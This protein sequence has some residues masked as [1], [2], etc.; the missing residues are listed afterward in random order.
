M[1]HTAIAVI[2]HSRTP[3][4]DDWHVDD[5]NKIIKQKVVENFDVRHLQRLPLGTSYVDQVAHVKALLAR[6]PLRFQD[7][8]L[9]LD[10]T[11][12]GAPVG[13]LFEAGGLKPIRV[14]F[15]A[16]K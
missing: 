4:P 11:G 13:D 16:S 6:P 2:D 3:I 14:T 1:D 12:V 15:T 8:A 5:A 7:V 9:C 10:Q